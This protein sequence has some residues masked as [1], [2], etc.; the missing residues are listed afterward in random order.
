M[1]KTK[2][3]TLCS[4][5]SSDEQLITHLWEEIEEA[6]TPRAYHNLKHLSMFYSCLNA[7][8]LTKVMEFAIFYHDIVYDVLAKENEERSAMVAQEKLQLL[9]VNNT[10]TKEVSELIIETKTHHPSTPTHALFLDADIAILGSDEDDYMN[11]CKQ[12]RKEYHLFNDSDYSRGRKKVL[13]HFL[14]KERLYKSDYFY[15]LYE[16]KARENLEREHYSLR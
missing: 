11:Y 13:E 3:K 6:H 10:L 12:I 7:S 1:L 9:G 2:F 8:Q 5:Y 16:K 15:G 4:H 14:A